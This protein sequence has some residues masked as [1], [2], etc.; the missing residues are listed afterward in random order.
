[1]MGALRDAIQKIPMAGQ[2]ANA[3]PIPGEAPP[4][5]QYED[6]MGVAQSTMIQPGDI[7]GMLAG[8]MVHPSGRVV[9]SNER[10]AIGSKVLEEGEKWGGR[11]GYRWKT[12]PVNDLQLQ[13]LRRTIQSSEFANTTFEEPLVNITRRSHESID[14]LQAAMADALQKGNARG[15]PIWK[16]RDLLDQA[17]IQRFPQYEN[18]MIEQERQAP[19]SLEEAFKNLQKQAES[20]GVAKPPSQDFMDMYHAKPKPPQ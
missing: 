5:S 15:K 3:W 9:L 6:R 11:M 16:V 18:W 4:L 20:M 14:D 8:S 19:I 17:G 12:Q 2:Y 7:A 10:G 1:M 13:K